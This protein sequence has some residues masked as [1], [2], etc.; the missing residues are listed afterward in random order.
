MGE[1]VSALDPMSA[2]ERFLRA[3]VWG[4]HL[5][6]WEMMSAVGHEYV[7]Q[8]GARRGLD[9]FLAQRIRFGTSTRDELD[10]FL[11]G[12]VHG[13]RV[14][15]SAVPLDDVRA[16]PCAVALGAETVDVPLECPATFGGACWAA[17]SIVLSRSGEN[18]LVDRVKPVLSRSE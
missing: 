4:E 17:G 11:T 3:I 6:V 9:P 7:L 15:F 13:L 8:A 1:A 16:A 18:W 5:T 14:D 2:A 10:S 12:V